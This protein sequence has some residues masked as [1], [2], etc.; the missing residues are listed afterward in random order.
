[1]NR[2]VFVLRVVLGVLALL[3][4]ALPGGAQTAPPVLRTNVDRLSIRDGSVYQ[5]AYWSL[6][7]SL[8]PDVY[9]A[10]LVN[11]RPHRVVFLS[12]VDSVAFMV[13][14]GR[15]YDF[16]VEK[17]GVRYNQRIVGTRMAPAPGIVAGRITAVANPARVCHDERSLPYLN[18][19][20]ILRNGTEQS[21]QIREMRALVFDARGN[22]IERRV[23]GQQALSLLGSAQTTGP[24]NHALLFNP[25]MFT[26]VDT[27][28]R[29]R[30]ET[31]FTGI[32]DPVTVEVTPVD[33]RNRSRFILPLAG[34]IAVYDGGD[35]L[36]HH[37]RSGYIG[38][39]GQQLGMVDNISRWSLDLVV[40]DADGRAFSGDGTRNEDWLSWG[41][42]VRAPADGVVYAVRGDQ[43]DNDVIGRESLWTDRNMATNP[44]SPSGNYV[45]I[46][47]G[48][49]E[50]SLAAH[51]KHGSVR[52][53][54]G[55][56]VRAGDVVAEVGNS[57]SSLGPHLHWELRSGFGVRGITA[58][59]A[60]F[61]DVKVLGEDVAEPVMVN[62]GD[63]LIAE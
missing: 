19:D 59:P 36:S 3:A 24:L 14:E 41:H 34:R 60:Y 13:E 51:V 32:A 8:D 45:L 11:G 16:T 33:C 30:Y 15:H 26:Q 63:V 47:H 57:G 43:P 54:Q 44:M 48:N 58:L 62:T 10:Q 29:V 61:H 9:N 35:V 39:G 50:F 37:R 7:P 31:Y 20:L 27:T 46:D 42:P 52:V 25:F 22:L 23:L 21:I 55:D 17:A 1:M 49:G 28:T 53:R 40:I 38:A 5:A 18:F 2:L 56:R 12:D 6:D 4:L